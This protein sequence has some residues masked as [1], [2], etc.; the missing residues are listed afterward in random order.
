MAPTLYFHPLSSYCH[1]ALIALYE[2]DTPFT[3]VMVDFGD[4]ASRTAFLKVWPLGKFPVIRDEA[5]G[6]TVAESTIIIE[7]TFPG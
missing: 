3:P 1:K 4:E 5:R 6:H 2:T 7:P